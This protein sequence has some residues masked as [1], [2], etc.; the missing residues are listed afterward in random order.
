MGMVLAE[1]TP[2]PCPELVRGHA[3]MKLGSGVDSDDGRIK[4][5]WYWR[6]RLPTPGYLQCGTD[7]PG[8]E[9]FVADAVDFAFR[10]LSA[11]D[12]QDLF[13]NLAADVVHRST[14]KDVSRVQIH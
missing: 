8:N 6:K 9:F 7:G 1:T 3:A 13:E 2:D 12:L 10:F 14:G 4:W 11:G 5:G